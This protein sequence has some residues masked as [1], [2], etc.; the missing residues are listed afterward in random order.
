MKKG[1]DK[2]TPKPPI[3]RE[4]GGDYYYTCFWLACG[5]DLKKWYNYCPKCGQKILWEGGEYE[6]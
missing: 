1:D 5:E 4:I 3:V 2:E 6:D